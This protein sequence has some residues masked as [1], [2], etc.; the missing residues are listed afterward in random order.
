MVSGKVSKHKRPIS[1]D[2]WPLGRDE[3]L[4]LHLPNRNLGASLHFTVLGAALAGRQ[5]YGGNNTRLGKGS[6]VPSLIGTG[7]TTRG[8]ILDRSGKGA[9]GAKATTSTS[10]SPDWQHHTPLTR[11]GTP[12]AW[13]LCTL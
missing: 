7:D 2:K 1:H 4:A 13:R 12:C 3:K 11:L 8:R 6:L 5:G 9:V 10:P